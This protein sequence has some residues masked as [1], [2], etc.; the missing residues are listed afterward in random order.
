MGFKKN[1]LYPMGLALTLSLV[2]SGGNVNV[3]KTIESKI[4]NPSDYLLQREKTIIPIPELLSLYTDCNQKIYEPKT[5][6]YRTRTLQEIEGGV[7]IRKGLEELWTSFYNEQI[8]VNK[9]LSSIV[10]TTSEWYDPLDGVGWFTNSFN[11]PRPRKGGRIERHGAIDLFAPVGTKIF[12][13][14]NGLVIGSADDWKGYWDRK[15]GLQYSQGG[16][17]GLSGNGIWIFNPVDT[18]YHFMIH[19]NDVYVSTGNVVLKGNLV[20]TVGRT[21]NASSPWSTTHLHYAWKKTGKGCGTEDV[22]IAQNPHENLTGVRELIL[23]QVTNK[24][25]TNTD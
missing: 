16:L 21:G 24:Q 9:S 10:D 4:E 13:P 12:S 3:P 1:I 19:F 6:T 17:G 5:A 2:S 20:G 22:L 23:A 8:G 15:R 11:F 7:K 18:S 14:V 25:Q